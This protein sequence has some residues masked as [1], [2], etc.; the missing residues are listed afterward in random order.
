MFISKVYVFKK[1]YNCGTN[2]SMVSVLKSLVPDPILKWLACSPAL[3]L[4]P[5][6]SLQHLRL[7]LRIEGHRGTV[8]ELAH[9]ILS[10][11][12]EDPCYRVPS[13]TPPTSR[14]CSWL[15][16]TSLR[17]SLED[18]PRTGNQSRLFSSLSS[19][20]DILAHSHPFLQTLHDPG[21]DSVIPTKDWFW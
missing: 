4:A 19:L 12:L 15:V 21:A 16:I 1:N 13:R 5:F 6:S 7:A 8:F 11:F 18:F 20:K 17:L 10:N 9:Q 14:R 2:A 3:P